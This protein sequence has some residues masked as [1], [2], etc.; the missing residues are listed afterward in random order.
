MVDAFLIRM[1]LI[2]ALTT[3]IG[4]HAWWL[5]GW[6]DRILPNVELEGA[7][8]GREPDFDGAPAAARR[9]SVPTKIPSG[10]ADLDRI[11]FRERGT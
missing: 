6:L 4:R 2:P 11:D 5:P 10:S 8:L 7:T 9:P 1:T 3:V